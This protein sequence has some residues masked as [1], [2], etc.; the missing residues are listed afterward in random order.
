LNDAVLKI[1]AVAAGGAVG[2]VA[3][4][5]ASLAAVRVLGDRFGWGTLVVNIVGCFALG[6]VA[7][8]AP[9]LGPVWHAGLGAGLLGGLTTF[10]TFSLETLRHLERGELGMA[11]LNVSLNLVVGL[12]ACA[13]GFAVAR[14][15]GA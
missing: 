12:A 1:V 2:S 3:R 6:V 15:W 5:A 13:A 9:R 4:Y 10:S 7:Q 11:L 8:V 14:S